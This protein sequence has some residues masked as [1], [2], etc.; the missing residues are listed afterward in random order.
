MSPSLESRLQ[1]WMKNHGLALKEYRFTLRRVG[2]SPLS[3]IGLSIIV[4]FV[5]MAV[6]APQ[7]APPYPKWN[8][9]PVP[10]PFIIPQVSNTVAPTPPTTGHPFGLTVDQYDIYYGCIWGTITA[11]RVGAYVVIISL[12]IGLTV[13]L[14]AGY[15][16]GLIDEVLMRFTDI[17]MAFPGLILALALTIALPNALS[18]SL[19]ILFVPLAAL[20]VI[21]AAANILTHAHERGNVCK[22]GDSYTS[23]LH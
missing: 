2:K 14:V 3:I 5:F 19:L 21:L 6:L 18:F 15:Y 11:F 4:F 7:L 9:S 20:F 10:D 12:I 23:S 13:G 16:G 1:D 22:N 17:V 8:I